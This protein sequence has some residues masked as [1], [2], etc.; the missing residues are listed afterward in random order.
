MYLSG[1]PWLQEPEASV[2]V[3]SIV[4]QRQVSGTVQFTFSLS[5]S[6]FRAPDHG[7]VPLEL[8]FGLSFSVNPI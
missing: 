4:K 6:Q 7:M 5:F 2:H 3:A 1:K 8:S